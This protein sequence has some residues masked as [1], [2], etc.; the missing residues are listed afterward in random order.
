[1]MVS[2]ERTDS[3]LQMQVECL[4]ELDRFWKELCISMATLGTVL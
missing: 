4:E 1:M 2:V 3:M